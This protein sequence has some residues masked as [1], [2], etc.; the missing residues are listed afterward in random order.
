[1]TVKPLPQTQAS[2]PAMD[3]DLDMDMDMEEDSEVV[4]VVHQSKV[5]LVDARTLEGTFLG[6]RACRH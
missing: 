2:D 1:M 6:S 4:D 5:L 3:V